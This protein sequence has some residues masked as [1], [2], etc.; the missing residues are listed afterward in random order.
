MPAPAARRRRWAWSATCW[1]HACWFRGFPPAPEQG[2]SRLHGS[3]RAR[4]TTVQPVQLS[5]LPEEYPA[6]PP[7]V[8][9]QL[10][11]ERLAEAISLVAG[12]IARAAGPGAGGAGDQQDNRAPPLR[13][14]RC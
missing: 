13:D 7:M 2:R 1:P 8:F 9:A 6:P 14:G 5:L 4:R 3:H 11:P 10:P 12:L